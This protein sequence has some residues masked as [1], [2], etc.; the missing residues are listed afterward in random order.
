MVVALYRARPLRRGRMVGKVASYS[1]SSTIPGARWR[2][3]GKQAALARALIMMMGLVMLM[4]L[5]M[6]MG[7]VVARVRATA[8]SSGVQR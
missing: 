1:P 2:P 7:K 4:L 5:L 6:L 8:S 3:R